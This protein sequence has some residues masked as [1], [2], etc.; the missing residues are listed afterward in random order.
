MFIPVLIVVWCVGWG[1]MM[2]SDMTRDELC[3]QMTKQQ[4][5]KADCPK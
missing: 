3:K 2:G 5:V 1:F 4:Q